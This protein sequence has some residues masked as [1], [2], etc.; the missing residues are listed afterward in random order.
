MTY[1]DMDKRKMMLPDLLGKPFAFT[2]SKGEIIAPT[3]VEFPKDSYVF[4]YPIQEWKEILEIRGG[5]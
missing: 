3:S 2:N 1:A 5:K 4:F